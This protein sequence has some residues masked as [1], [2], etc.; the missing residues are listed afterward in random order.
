MVHGRSWLVVWAVC[1]IAVTGAAPV[2]CLGAT[3]LCRARGTTAGSGR[4]NRSVMPFDVPG[5]T[6]ATVPRT[7]SSLAETS[8]GACN[9]RSDWD[10]LLE[11]G[12][13]RGIPS[14][15]RSPAG[16]DYVPALCTHRPSV[17]PIGCAAQPGGA[18]DCEAMRGLASRGSKSRNKVSVG[19]PAEG[20]FGG[21]QGIEGWRD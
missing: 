17:L 11:C 10:R 15:C 14:R 7:A 1:L 9:A 5:C 20:S 2:Q 4:D 19:E 12:L 6:R 16:A 13:E 3:P 18:R 8:G 21:I